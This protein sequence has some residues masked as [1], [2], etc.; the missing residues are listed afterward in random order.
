MQTGFL[1]TTTQ[2]ETFEVLVGD[3][4]AVRWVDGSGTFSTESLGAKPVEGGH[5]NNTPLFIAQAPYNGGV[6]P[7]KISNGLDGM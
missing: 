3:A 5:E 7:G 1:S 2:L 6:H 4:R